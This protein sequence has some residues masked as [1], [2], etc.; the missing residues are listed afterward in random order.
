MFSQRQIL[1][2]WFFC[3][4]MCGAAVESLHVLIPLTT[5]RAFDSF[6]YST[7]CDDGRRTSCASA[8]AEAP[9]KLSK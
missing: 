2:M 4:L 5:E 7:G 9:Q 3:S 8:A 6:Y 1:L